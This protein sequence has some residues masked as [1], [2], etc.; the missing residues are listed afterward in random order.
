MYIVC[1]LLFFRLYYKSLVYLVATGAFAQIFVSLHDNMMS[2]NTNNN[3]G[4]PLCA[5]FPT[6]TLGCD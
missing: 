3:N 6:M 1:F 2:T 4:E 5:I